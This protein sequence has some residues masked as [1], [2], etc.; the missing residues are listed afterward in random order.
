MCACVHKYMHITESN[1]DFINVRRNY[2]GDREYVDSGK[3]FFDKTQKAKMGK[4]GR[5]LHRRGGTIVH[6]SNALSV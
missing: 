1:K 2:G 5:T 4:L 3:A 6:K